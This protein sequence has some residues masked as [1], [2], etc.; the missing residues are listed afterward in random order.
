MF[1]SPFLWQGDA[2]AGASAGSRRLQAIVRLRLPR[3]GTVRAV[4]CHHSVRSMGRVRT[5][6]LGQSLPRIYKT[7]NQGLQSLRAPEP[8]AVGPKRGRV[9][10]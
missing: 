4:P 8:D 2:F 10:S 3:A 1:N 9:T 5:V 7:K 6:D